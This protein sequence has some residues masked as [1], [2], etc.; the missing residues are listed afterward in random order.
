[1]TFHMWWFNSPFIAG[2]KVKELEASVLIGKHNSPHYFEEATLQE[3]GVHKSAP[4]QKRHQR[5]VIYC[6][7]LFFKNWSN[8]TQCSETV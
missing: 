6:S 2:P 5:S 4:L 7:D 1:M 3:V 8:L